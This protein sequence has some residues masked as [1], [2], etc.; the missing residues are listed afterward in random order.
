M[1]EQAKWRPNVFFHPNIKDLKVSMQ[2]LE[3][4]DFYT[5]T[6]QASLEAFLKKVMR[7]SLPTLEDKIDG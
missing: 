2:D 5:W 4:A 7:D 6:C 1:K 3:R